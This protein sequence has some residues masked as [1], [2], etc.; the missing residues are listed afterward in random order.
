MHL[1]MLVVGAALF[2]WG[3]L[4]DGMLSWIAF[5]IGGGAAWYAVEKMAK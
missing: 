2:F 1:V 3:L 5:V 4:N